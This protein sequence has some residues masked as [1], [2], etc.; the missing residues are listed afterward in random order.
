LARD[1]N[2][3]TLDVSLDK[4]TFLDDEVVVRNNVSFHVAPQSNFS[5]KEHLSLE[6]RAFGEHG[7][8]A[9]ADAGS[10]VFGAL[11]LCEHGTLLKNSVTFGIGASACMIG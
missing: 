11:W 5:P 9:C 2:I 1:L 7:N 8:G 6:R 4:G 3:H 10:F